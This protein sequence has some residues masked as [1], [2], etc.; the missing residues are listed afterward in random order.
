MGN[1]LSKNILLNFENIAYFIYIGVLVYIELGNPI[2]TD[3]E[4]SSSDSKDIWQTLLNPVFLC[5]HVYSV[6]L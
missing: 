5:V 3:N 1:N 6:L 4:N 2:V